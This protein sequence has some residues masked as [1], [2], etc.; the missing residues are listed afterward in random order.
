S[1]LEGK[2][3]TIATLKCLG[4]PAGLVFRAYLLQVMLLTALGVA[5]GLAVG[6]GLPLLLSGLLDELLPF[7]AQFG[8]HPLPLL[9][10]AVYGFLTALAFAIW[11][12]ARA[13]EVPAGAL[14]RD[15][16]APL[17]ARPRWQY[18]ALTLAV[19][20]ALAGLAILTAEER[21]FAIW[22]V[23]GAMGAMLAFLAAGNGIVDLARWLPRPR[24]SVLRLAM[25]NL[26]R[27]GAPTVPVVQSFGLGL[28][29]L[30]AVMGVEGNMSVQV[31][32]RLPERAPAFFF[33]D[34][35]PDQVTP[36]EKLAMAIDGVLAVE[37]VPA[38]RGRIVKVNGVDAAEVKVAPEAAWAVR[39]D[40]G[41][42]YA[43]ERPDSAEVVA[44]KWWPAD[45]RGPPLVS[46]DAAIARGLDI[47]IGD[48]LTVNVLGR[49]IEA[50]I[51]NL[52]RIDWSTLGINFVIVFA[53]GALE[54]A[55]HTFVA[56]AKTTEAAELPLQTAVTDSFANV[57]AIRVREALEAVNQIL[58]NIGIAVRATASVTLAAGILV[59]AGAITASH[60]RRVYDS[61]I[62][63][64]LGATR[65]RV[66]LTYLAEYALLGLVTALL[67]AGI[68]TAAAYAV[69]AEIM[70][71]PWYWMPASVAGTALLCLAL[72]LGAGMTGTWLALSQKPAPLLRNE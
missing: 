43:A 18:M 31:T 11:P 12:L 3:A 40:R 49:E 5:L 16:A 60:R 10:A 62:L 15:L 32:E 38:L 53:P 9:L 65:R 21:R 66:L 14:F 39:G 17:L 33:I 44:G 41:L 54:G 64:V 19:F 1:F 63:K 35:L 7:K 2:T 29:V 22:F 34:I 23:C 36:F 27:P 28:S 67:A 46:F 55:P 59:L 52:R 71:L 56:T 25:A 51:G 26:H 13:R 61:V 42:T 37:R 45:Y 20:A 68:G 57:T 58:R 30:V 70:N 47:G 48:R 24:W 6:A 50:T 72:T 69:V 4:A 8:F